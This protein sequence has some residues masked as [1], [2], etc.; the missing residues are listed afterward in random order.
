MWFFLLSGRV[1]KGRRTRM[2]SSDT[3][4]LR[5][6]AFFKLVKAVLLVLTGIGLLKLV[7][8]DPAVEL[9]HWILKLGLDPGSRFLNHAIERVTNI[10]PHR[11]KE[12]GIGTFV[13]AALFLTEGIGL[14][15]LKR[16]AEWFTVIAT[17]SLIPIEAYEIYRHPTPVKF[18]VLILNAA[19]VVYLAYRILRTPA[20]DSRVAAPTTR[21]LFYLWERFLPW[22]FIP[23]RR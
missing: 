4:L 2:H 3:G 5:L 9:Q 21:F 15:Q 20:H 22:L 17:G 12:L 13:Y 1:A 14:W 23:F 16:W 11:I 6:I 19:I 18:V 7:H 10:P 8:L